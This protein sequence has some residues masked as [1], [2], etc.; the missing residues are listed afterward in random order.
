MFCYEYISTWDRLYEEKLPQKSK[1]YSSLSK[2]GISDS[3]YDR[4]ITFFE[5]FECENIAQYCLAYC[6][7][8]KCLIT[9]SLLFL[10]EVNDLFSFLDVLLLADCVEQLRH[11]LFS[12]ANLDV[13]FYIGLAAYGL[14]FFLKY[15]KVIFIITVVFPI[16]RCQNSSNFR[17]N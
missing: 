3:D 6:E 15:T 10:S 1:F 14:D 12:K 7:S 11:E 16:L 17:L 5:T 8:G 9:F 2:K 4:A 13:F